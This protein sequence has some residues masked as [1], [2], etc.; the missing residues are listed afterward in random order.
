M[1]LDFGLV[2]KWFKKLSHIHVL[3]GMNLFL[4]SFGF[5]SLAKP[6]KSW[7]VSKS[8]ETRFIASTQEA[9]PEESFSEMKTIEF[10]CKSLTKETNAKYIRLDLNAC[11]NGLGL[12]QAIT[13]ETT[14][15]KASILKGDG[16]ASTEFFH[17]KEGKNEIQVD[18]LGQANSVNLVVFMNS[19]FTN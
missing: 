15:T 16:V 19:Q 6:T 12:P 1:K 10:H 13:N 2:M 18:M 7:H 8:S 11:L 5:W 14:G 3:V 4:L 17:L 9:I